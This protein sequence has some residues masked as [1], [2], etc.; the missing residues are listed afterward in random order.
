LPPQS[1][2][3][4]TALVGA[5]LAQGYQIVLIPSVAAVVTVYAAVRE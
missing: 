4:C 2:N 5:W 1:T 3:L